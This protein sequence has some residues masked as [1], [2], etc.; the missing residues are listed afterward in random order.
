[1]ATA[2]KAQATKA[3]A[4]KAPA[5]AAP[6]AQA[7]GAPRVCA[8][9]GQ[10]LTLTAGP[11]MQGG[12]RCPKAATGKCGVVW[13]ACTALANQAG[14]NPAAVTAAAVLPLVAAAL[15]A[16]HNPNNTKLEVSAWRKWHGFGVA[17]VAAAI[18]LPKG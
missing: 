9:T 2:T 8:A 12:Y 3:P 11:T 5:Q 4:A 13:A 10:A 1:M 14:G 15:G 17:P 6:A 16:A 7:Q 18:V